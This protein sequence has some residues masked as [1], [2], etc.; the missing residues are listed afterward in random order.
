VIS[1]SLPGEVLSV[2]G[3]ADGKAVSVAEK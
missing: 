2:G 1:S 3:V